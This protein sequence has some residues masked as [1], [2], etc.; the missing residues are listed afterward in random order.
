MP[1]GWNGFML[2]M[3]LAAS[4]LAAG[5]APAQLANHSVVLGGAPASGKGAKGTAFTVNVF[6]NNL[7][8]GPRKKPTCTEKPDA[9]AEIAPGCNSV[10]SELGL[11]I[12]IKLGTDAT[13]SLAVGINVI[14]IPPGRCIF[15]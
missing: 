13:A 8:T 5:A 14:L 3:I 2:A 1:I 15:H 4:T 6:I 11:G 7:I 12:S 10:F 9:T